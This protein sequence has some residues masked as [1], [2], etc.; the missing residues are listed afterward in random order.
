MKLHLRREILFLGVLFAAFALAAGGYAL[1]SNR[2]GQPK[3]KIGR[4]HV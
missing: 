4:A 2:Y 3:T 1:G